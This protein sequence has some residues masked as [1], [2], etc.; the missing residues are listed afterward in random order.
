MEGGVQTS[1]G[2]LYMILFSLLSLQRALQFKVRGSKA[3]VVEEAAAIAAAIAAAM[4]ALDSFCWHS[5][6]NA[7]YLADAAH[8]SSAFWQS[9]FEICRFCLK[10]SPE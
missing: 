1:G 5:S 7:C 8:L 2:I 6:L 3:G 10:R 9:I 4:R